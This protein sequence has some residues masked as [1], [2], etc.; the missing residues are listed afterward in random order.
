METTTT[1]SSLQKKNKSPTWIIIR[2]KFVD[3]VSCTRGLQCVGTE[4]KRMPSF[5]HRI[6]TCNI[7]RPEL[8]DFLYTLRTDESVGYC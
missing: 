5:W 6:S 8:T 2:R 4:T 7:T 3:G 1:P